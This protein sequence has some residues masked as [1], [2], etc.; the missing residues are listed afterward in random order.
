M[1]PAAVTPP[2]I[3]ELP[4]IDPL[5]AQK[6]AT[7][8]AQIADTEKR[9]IIWFLHWVSHQSGGLT[10]FA[11]E[12]LC[13]F[14]PTRLGTPTMR[15]TGI[16]P[17]I[18]Y[19]G[20][21]YEDIC[22]EIRSYE[23][24]PALDVEREMDFYLRCPSEFGRR[25]L[26]ELQKSIKP[27]FRRATCPALL[28]VCMDSCYD[29]PTHLSKL[30]LDSKTPWEHTHFGG[31]YEAVRE[32]IA[33]RIKFAQSR[34]APTKIASYVHDAMSFAYRNKSLAVIHGTE[35][36]GKSVATRLWQ[37]SNAG[38]A[39]LIDLTAATT[40][41]LFYHELFKALGCGAVKRGDANELRA[42]IRAAVENRDLM[43]IFDEAHCL[44]GLSARASVKRLEYIRTEFVN[45]GIPVVL[46]V[47]PQ[48]SDRLR[49]ME[50][51][52]GFNTN[53]FRGRIT[54]WAELPKKPSRADVECVCR[55]MLPTLDDE[56]AAL[57]VDCAMSAE[58]PLAALHNAVL[59]ARSIGEKEGREATAPDIIRTAIGY[60]LATRQMVDASIPAAHQ[61]PKRHRARF[62]ASPSVIQNRP[63]ETAS[64]GRIAGSVQP[65]CTRH[66]KE[67]PATI[68]N[69]AQ[70]ALCVS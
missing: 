41:I 56:S 28:Q 69:R 67:V 23:H 11:H 2:T 53:Q 37:E 64:A 8:A 1:K 20:A 61:M 57:L 21:T 13:D 14:I 52:T 32:A 63:P 15:E 9:Q 50:R 55:F 47:T 6:V 26:P 43:L 5:P 68:T 17:N 54:K 51:T 16:G 34:S 27:G 44:F 49:E 48:F 65:A 66:A 62:A 36:L 31:F 18:V 7:V 38:R 60:S 70:N 22:I 35:R 58:T 45:R 3:S 24:P 19:S 59:E 25:R 30:C 39:R 10:R 40:D 33:Q 29:L 4:F 46:V 42:G 12:M